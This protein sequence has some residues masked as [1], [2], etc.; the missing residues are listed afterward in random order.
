MR[1]PLTSPPC[2][3]TIGGI[4][5]GAQLEFEEIETDVSGNPRRALVVTPSAKLRVGRDRLQADAA[6]GKASVL[7]GEIVARVAAS[8]SAPE[9][10]LLRSWGG[11]E[12]RS[13]GFDAGLTAAEVD[14]L[15]YAIMRD[16]LAFFRDVI[17]LGVFAVVATDL[18]AVEFDAM[19]HATTRLT[20]ELGGRAR[21]GTAD[22]DDDIDRWILE[23][24]SLWTTRPFDEFVLQALPALFTLIDR[25]RA[26]LSAL[27]DARG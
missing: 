9:V 16:Q 21:S 5:S 19:R 10:V 13:W 8:S 23:H 20:R 15:G 6:P 24:L 14:E 18:T 7:D 22:A 1:G 26:R 25:H 12:E 11:A 4:V 3:A 2:S 17:P 27:S